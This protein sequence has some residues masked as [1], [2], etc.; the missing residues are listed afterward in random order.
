MSLSALGSPSKI[1][2]VSFALNIGSPW[3]YAGLYNGSFTDGEILEFTPT[4]RLYKPK[5]I[6]IIL[7]YKI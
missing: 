3:A 4:L 5:L 6:V 2:I 7:V 1:A